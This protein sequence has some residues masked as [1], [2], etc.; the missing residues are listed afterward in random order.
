MNIKK[1]KKCGKELPTS[2]FYKNKACNDGLSSWCKNCMKQ[3][4]K[5]SYEE[6]KEEIIKKAKQYYQGNKEKVL[7]YHKKYNESNKN[8]IN[9]YS[10][11]Y[12]NDNKEYILK[13]YKEKHL[14][15]LGH[16]YSVRKSN[17]SE[18]RKYGRVGDNLPDNYPKL[19]DYLEILQQP[20]FYDK[21]QYH[22]SEM[23]VDRIDNNKPHTLDNIVPCST[24]NNKKRGKTYTHEEFI[25]MMLQN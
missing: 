16:C 15:L 4:S 20:D 18:D 25:E 17:I 10:K 14:T 19:E 21:K 24:K 13:Y 9:E 8:K 22:F 1:C 12:Y 6:N 11:K 23:G 2:N 5:Q 3:N 7:E